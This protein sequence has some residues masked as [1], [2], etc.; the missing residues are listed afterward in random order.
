MKLYKYILILILF[1]SCET[2]KIGPL[3]DENTNVIFFSD[4][5][6]YESPNEDIFDETASTVSVGEQVTKSITVEIGAV[7]ATAK[8]T[9]VTIGGT[10]VEGVDYTIDGSLNFDFPAGASV[11]S[12]SISLIDNNNFDDDHTIVLSLPSGEGYSEDNRRELIINIINNEVSSGTVISSIESESD[13]AEEGINGNSP[14]NIDLESSDIEFGEVEG[15]TRGTEII[16]L[17]FNKISIPKGATITSA[18]IQFTVDEDVDNPAD[19]VM[20]IFGEAVDNA[21]TFTST[22]F[23]ISNRILTTASV[24]WNIPVW[25]TVGEAGAS[26][27]TTD[28]KSVIQEIVNRSGWEYDNSLNIIFSPTAATLANPTESGRVAEAGPGSDA[29]TITIEWEL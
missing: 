19:V 24:D 14:G 8:N 28:I 23:D 25:A 27:K 15:S 18:S 10:A 3:L 4:A 20:T 22:D 21:T 17:R 26:Q 6:F 16:G 11:Q 5:L 2:D 29:A 13:D 12:I 7:L 1:I 9:Q